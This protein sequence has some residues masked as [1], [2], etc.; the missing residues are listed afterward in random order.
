MKRWTRGGLRMVG[1]AMVL[2]LVAAACGGGDEATKEDLVADL[3]GDNLFTQEQAECFVDAIWDDIGPLNVG[4]IG[5]Q[6]DLTPAQAAALTEAT[7][8]C[9]DVGDLIQDPTPATDLS[10]TD[11]PPGTDPAMDALWVACGGGDAEACDDLFFQ[12][13]SGS[14]YEEFGLTCGGRGMGNCVSVIADS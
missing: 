8:S 14:D 10:P 1:L 9:I 2:A 4:Q 6:D 3:V 12:S 7:F 11:R 5:S 13:P